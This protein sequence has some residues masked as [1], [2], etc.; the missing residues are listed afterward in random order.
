MLLSIFYTSVSINH[1]LQNKQ[2]IPC[3]DTYRLGEK[4]SFCMK[5]GS[6]KTVALAFVTII[7]CKLAG[8][9]KKGGKIRFDVKN[10]FF[11]T[12]LQYRIPHDGAAGFC[13]QLAIIFFLEKFLFF[14]RYTE[15][16]TYPDH[17]VTLLITVAKRS[18]CRISI[19]ITGVLLHTDTLSQYLIKLLTK[20]QTLA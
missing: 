5:N 13:L 10:T 14:K 16:C 18:N 12:F 11:Q 3:F 17:R 15:K 9:G 4:M 1:V 2:T 7:W 6:H 8:C 20:S 19:G